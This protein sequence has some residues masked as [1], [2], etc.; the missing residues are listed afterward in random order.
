MLILWYTLPTLNSAIKSLLNSCEAN[1]QT[2]QTPE[3]KHRHLD[4]MPV[5]S[6]QK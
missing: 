5:I 2:N 3:K 4:I 1:K 6:I